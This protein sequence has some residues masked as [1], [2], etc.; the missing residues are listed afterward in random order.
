MQQTRTY[1]WA[2]PRD[3]AK[4]GR[5]LSGLDFM[6]LLASEELGRTPMLATL[7]ITFVAV[8]EGYIIC[9]CTCCGRPPATSARSTR[10]AGS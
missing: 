6:R 1:D 5:G 3:L 9:R 7:A 8:E 10:S 2:D 4:A